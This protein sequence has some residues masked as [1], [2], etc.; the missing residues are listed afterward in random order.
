MTWCKKRV[1]F[2]ISVSG[3]RK[4]PQFSGNRAFAC[5]EFVEGVEPK[6]LFVFNR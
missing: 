6:A 2:Q 1:F 3:T 4:M 5:P